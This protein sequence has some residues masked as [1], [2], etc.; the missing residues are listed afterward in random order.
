MAGFLEAVAGLGEGEAV[1]LPWQGGDER[2]ARRTSV[3]A[4]RIR[5]RRRI[6]EDEAGFLREHAGGPFK[7]TLPSALLLAQAAYRPGLSDRAYASREDLVAHA[8][9]VLADEARMLVEE[10]VH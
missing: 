7:V 6:A 3:V 9:D 4:A 5:P 2:P 1:A 8:G 10:G